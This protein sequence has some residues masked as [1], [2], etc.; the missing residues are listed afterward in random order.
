MLNVKL[1]NK[2]GQIVALFHDLKEAYQ[3]AQNRHIEEFSVQATLI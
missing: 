3:Y 1:L 2:S